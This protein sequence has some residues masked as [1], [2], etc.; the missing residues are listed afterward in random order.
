MK[1]KQQQIIWSLT[2]VGGVLF[3]QDKQLKKANEMYNNMAYIDAMDVYKNLAKSDDASAEVY[4][5]L[6]D[7]NYFNANYKDA[8][9]WY[10]KAFAMDKNLPSEYN[11]RYG[12]SLKS[13]GQMQKADTYLNRFY[14]S[15]A[16]KYEPSTTYMSAIEKASGRHSV[17]KVN[18]NSKFSDYPAFMNN[19]QLYVVTADQ[20]NKTNPWNEEPASDIYVGSSLNAMDK[21]INT[22]Y[23][24][25]SLVI[26]KDGQTLYFTRNDYVEN[27]LG[28]DSQKVTRLKLLRSDKVGDQWSKPK[29]LPFNSSEYSVGHPALSADESKLYFVSDMPGGKGGT[30]LYE[31]EISG[32]NSYGAPI[33]LTAFNTVGN[34]MFPFVDQDDTF[35]FSSNGHP[36]L[37]GLDVFYVKTNADGAFEGDVMNIGKPINSNFDDFAIVTN[38]ETGYFASNRDNQNDDIYSFNQLQPLEG[39]C[40]VRF[41]GVVIDKKTGKPIPNA[42]VFFI[43]GYLKDVGQ[44]KADAQGRY[45]FE[46]EK[47][48]NISIIRA[49]ET[50]YF[51][52]EVV[53]SGKEGGVVKTNIP[54]NIQKVEVVTEIVSPYGEVTTPGTD[55]A[56][57]LN[58]IYFDLDKSFIRSDARRELNKVVSIMNQ[59][60]TLEIDVRSHTDSRAS[61]AYNMALSERRNRSTIQYLVDKGISRSRLTGRGYGETQLVNHCSNGVQCPD[62]VHEQNRR[63]EFIITKR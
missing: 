5:K 50:D 55:L 26:T 46:D 32:D 25:G 11:F 3:A 61:D 30:D 48:G 34:E 44:I 14:R 1:N 60:P 41:E 62:E 43:N 12:Q 24:E 53:V 36:N 19:D 52:N 18:F 29:E 39:P 63:S 57:F 13:I 40:K 42:D 35:Y 38:G 45:S 22:K 49:D 37:G 51:A 15:N 58:P 9:N 47:C 10:A 56:I 28:T 6:G 17:E 8:A 33:N 59:Y 27:K 20:S 23:N 16:A 54:L 31:S 4:Q 21:P 7:V 2:L